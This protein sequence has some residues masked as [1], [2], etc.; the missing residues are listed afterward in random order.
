MARDFQRSDAYQHRDRSSEQAQGSSN[1]YTQGYQLGFELGYI[2]GYYGRTRNSAVPVNAENRS[3]AA[4]LTNADHARDQELAREQQLARDQQ[5]ARDQQAAKDQQVARDQQ[6]A[7]D[8]W[9]RRGDPSHARSSEPVIIPDDTEIRLRLTTP[10][11]TRTS[12]S[13]DRFRA[14]VLPPSGSFT[15]DSRSRYYEGATIEGH[16]ASLNRSGRVNGRTELALAFD[17]IT[18]ADGRRGA[19]NADLEKILESETVKKVDEEGRIESGNRTRD[20]EVRGGVGA[21]AGA[22]IG[23]LIGGGKGAIIGLLVGGAAGVGTVYVEGNNDLILE[24]GTE[25]VIRTAGRRQQ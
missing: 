13:G 8:A 10:I 19:L 14:V 16:I 25:M 20:S 21:G 3:N 9:D 6:A 15:A 11:S 23:G 4:A 1:Q 22:L 17:S 24:N 12:K 5:G 2:D 7:R 18:L